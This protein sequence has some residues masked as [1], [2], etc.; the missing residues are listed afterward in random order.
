MQEQISKDGLFETV[1]QFQE[2]AS[3]MNT[4]MIQEIVNSEIA[5]KQMATVN[6]MNNYNMPVESI[7]AVNKF[8]GYIKDI[9]QMIQADPTL[10]FNT[11]LN[12]AVEQMKNP[13]KQQEKDGGM[14]V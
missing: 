12:A 1:S 10:N 11:V 5:D 14:T 6:T 2:Q 13:N 7:D 8:M 9:S 4:E 3:S